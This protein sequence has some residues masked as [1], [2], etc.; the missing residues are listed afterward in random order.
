MPPLPLISGH[1]P[2]ATHRSNRAVPNTTGRSTATTTSQQQQSLAQ[3]PSSCKLF[4][5]NN[6]YSAHLQAQQQQHHRYQ[7]PGRGTPPT[8]REGLAIANRRAQRRSKSADIWLD[9]KPPTVAKIGKS[10][11]HSLYPPNPPTLTQT[12]SFNRKCHA[13]Y[14]LAKLSYQMQKNHQNTF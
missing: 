3:T 10:T 6:P 8:P 11:I 13:K 2:L 4:S 14:Q 1:T 12:L 9:H 7:S 5:I